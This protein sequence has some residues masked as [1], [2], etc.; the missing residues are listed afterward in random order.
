MRFQIISDSLLKSFDKKIK[1]SVK[2]CFQEL[3]SKEFA[4]DDFKNY[5]I[6]G[7]VASS[8]IEGS[9]LDLNSFY[10]SKQNKTNKK[11]VKEIE[12]LL[13]A[14]QYAK[15]Y[16]LTQKGLLKCHEILAE[17]FTNITKSQ[18]G[19]YR[20]TMV[21]IRGWSGLVYLAVEPQFVQQEMSKLFEDID[22]LLKQ[23]LT[24]KE[25]L[26][27]ASY[28]HFVFAKIHPFADGN[29][30]AARLLEKWFL[31][32]VLGDGVWGIP[33]E[34]YYYDNRQDY[35]SSLNVGVNYYETIER[36]NQV[37]PFLILLP[38]A[39]CYKPLD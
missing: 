16:R 18:K 19:K 13:T 11:E 14:Y 39:V 29:G 2:K 22:Q 20:K 8:Q 15:R 17:T 30:R 38:Q 23:E 1:A 34:K 10:Q 26:Y 12:N 4:V 25:A 3:D 7:A 32:E 36:L 33:S 24:L 28:I 9:T 5:M 31:A 21:G 35:Y 37:L 6:A 27:Y